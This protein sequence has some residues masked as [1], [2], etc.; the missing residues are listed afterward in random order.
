MSDHEDLQPL[1]DDEAGVAGDS[2]FADEH[3]STAVDP[4]ITEG[5]DAREEESPRGWSGLEKS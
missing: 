3:G 5:S 4:A 1:G 2:D